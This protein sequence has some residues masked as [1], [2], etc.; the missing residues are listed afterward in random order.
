MFLDQN[1]YNILSRRRNMYFL[2]SCYYLDDGI[3]MQPLNSLTNLININK[4]SKYKYKKILCRN[5]QTQIAN[6]PT[7]T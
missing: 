5:N 4:I 3:T 1:R 7:N 2:I 6:H